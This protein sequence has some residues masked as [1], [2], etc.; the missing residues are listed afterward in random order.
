MNCSLETISHV[1]VYSKKNR[2]KKRTETLLFIQR[3]YP[4]ILGGL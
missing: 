2:K 1:G 4:K 3:V